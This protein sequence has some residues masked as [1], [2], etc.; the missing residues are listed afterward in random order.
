MVINGARDLHLGIPRV[1]VI[2]TSGGHSNINSSQ[3]IESV[4]SLKDSS[5]TVFAV[6]V[7]DRINC[8]Q[9]S[10]IASSPDKSFMIDSFN[11]VYLEEIENRIVNDVYK[12]TNFNIVHRIPSV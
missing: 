12:G 2:I 7:D 4:M 8:C 1:A 3:N 5:V 9:L 10:S 6:S 11:D